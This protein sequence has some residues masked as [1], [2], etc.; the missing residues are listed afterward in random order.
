[1]RFLFIIRIRLPRRGWK[2]LQ[3]N[4]YGA[5]I[6]ARKRSAE[7]TAQ[8]GDQG[9]ADQGNAAASH[10]LFHTQI[11]VGNRLDGGRR[12]VKKYLWSFFRTAP[13]GQVRL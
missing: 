6:A 7:Q 5:A 4:M 3:V 12:R 2:C 9:D 10:E 11:G 8:Q 1:M 13:A